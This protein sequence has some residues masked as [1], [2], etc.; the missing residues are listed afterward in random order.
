MVKSQAFYWLIIVL[1]F[2]NTVIL[3]VEHYG[4]E[5]WLNRFQ[6]MFASCCRGFYGNN[7]FVAMTSTIN[8]LLVF[9]VSITNEL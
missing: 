5:P 3:S 1:V 7:P 4:Q 6:G 2:L 9:L 8:I